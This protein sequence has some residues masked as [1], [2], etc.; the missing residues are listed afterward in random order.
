MTGTKAGPWITGTV[1]VAMAIM[2]AAWFLGVSPQ[3]TTAAENKEQT[4]S[5]TDANRQLESKITVLSQQFAKLDEYKASLAASRV[6][7]PTDPQLA[8]YQRELNQIASAHQVVVVNLN[9]SAS[10]EVK[11]QLAAPEPSPAAD[12]ATTSGDGTSAETT[13][14]PAEAAVASLDVPGFFQVPVSVEVLGT[15]QNVLAFL[16]DAQAGTTRLLM[17]TGITGTSQ[18]EG[19][20]SAG[21]PATAAGDL[22]MIVTGALFV[23]T[24]PAAASLPVVDPAAPKPALPVPPGDK[25]P[26]VPLP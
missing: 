2:L 9:V 12:D 17:V 18:S 25:N 22:N 13:V 19:E 4:E 3:L 10:S 7:I 23:L 15:Y 20:A 24:D 26:F 6:Q 16:Q 14:D 21:R 5:Q 1:V 11:L 8:A